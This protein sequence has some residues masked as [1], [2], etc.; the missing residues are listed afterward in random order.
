MRA[1]M[2]AI[3]MAMTFCIVAIARDNV[4][5]PDFACP[6][7]VIKQSEAALRTALR[8]SDGQATV[9]ALL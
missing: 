3:F 9:S 4:D 7:K 2:I 1:R 5:T 6:R 8:K